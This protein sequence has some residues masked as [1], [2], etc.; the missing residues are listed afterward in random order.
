M[1]S[2][3]TRGSSSP[4]T[5]TS[6]PASMATSL[7]TTSGREKSWGEIYTG[8]RHHFP[9]LHSTQ[10]CGHTHRLFCLPDCERGLTRCGAIFGRIGQTTSTPCTG[11][12]TVGHR[13]SSSRLLPPTV[14]STLPENYLR[15]DIASAFHCVIIR[16]LQRLDDELN[17]WA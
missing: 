2:S 10:T 8:G 13:G 1:P 3:S 4:F 14:L 15:L 17:I 12:D 9:F 6:T 11:L 7:A 16:L 5:A